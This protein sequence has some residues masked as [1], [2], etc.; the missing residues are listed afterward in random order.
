V[1]TLLTGTALSWFAPFLE[2]NSPLL[3]TFEEFIKQFK[4][5]FGD[6][7]SVRTTIHKIRTLQQGDQP[8]STYAANFCLITSDIPWEEQALM[9][10]FRWGLRGNVKDLLLTFPEDP[11]SLT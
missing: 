10:Q 1:G 11:K 5:F 2:T 8:A 9:K 6:T 3:K 4:D 7:D